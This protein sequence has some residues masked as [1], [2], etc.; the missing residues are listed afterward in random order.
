M[1][2]TLKRGAAY[3]YFKSID[4]YAS[5]INL[6]YNGKTFFPT[7]C[8]GIASVLTIC[9]C[10][11]WLAALAIDHAFHPSRNFSLVAKT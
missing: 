7:F 5:G 9:V 11:Y 8:G 2:R 3:N 4:F 6:T 1:P 10:L